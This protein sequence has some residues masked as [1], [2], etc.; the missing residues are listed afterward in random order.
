MPWGIDQHPPR[1]NFEGIATGSAAATKRVVS[2]AVSTSAVADWVAI[3][4]DCRVRLQKSASTAEAIPPAKQHAIAG[5]VGKRTARASH[6]RVQVQEK[7][8]AV[9]S[10]RSSQRQYKNVSSHEASGAAVT[11]R[12]RSTV[13]TPSTVAQVH[14]ACWASS[15]AQEALLGRRWGKSPKQHFAAI[16]GRLQRRFLVG[17]SAASR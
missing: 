4:C 11:L 14:G 10:A 2:A 5:E 15:D 8:L 16:G 13:T 9:R 6:G 17:L 3:A 12:T 7:A 1:S